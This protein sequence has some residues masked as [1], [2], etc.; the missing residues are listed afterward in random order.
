M[1]LPELNMDESLEADSE[2]AEDLDEDTDELE[3]EEASDVDPMFAADMEETGL[4]LDDR[5]L[6]AL[7]RAMLGLWSNMGGGGGMGS[8][9]AFPV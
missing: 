7:Q 4:D 5:Q 8:P 2:L 9:P 3:P 6:A 1:A